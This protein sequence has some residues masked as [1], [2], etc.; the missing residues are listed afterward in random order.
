MATS[1]EAIVEPCSIKDRTSSF[2]V[3]AIEWR[4]RADRR[5]QQRKQRRWKRKIHTGGRQMKTQTLRLNRTIRSLSCQVCLFLSLHPPSLVS[6]PI[7]SQGQ[8][9]SL[10]CQT[11]QTLTKSNWAFL[12]RHTKQQCVCHFSLFSL[13]PCS[14]FHFIKHCLYYSSYILCSHQFALLLISLPISF[15]LP[16]QQ[17]LFPLW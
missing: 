12:E 11:L 8:M 16:E 10:P 7:L 5:N 4:T 15:R 1:W 6:V 13:V 3:L 2:S 14:F 9:S 17:T